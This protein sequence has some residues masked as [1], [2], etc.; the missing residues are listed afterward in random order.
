MINILVTSRELDVAG[1]DM[2]GRLS[3]EPGFNVYI[4]V[5]SEKER[6]RV[7]GACVAVDIPPL[8]SKFVLGGG[9]ITP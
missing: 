6:S 9:K 4:A 2:L 8:S 3:H 5:S 7:K 1:Y